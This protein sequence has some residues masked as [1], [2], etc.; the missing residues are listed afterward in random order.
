MGKGEERPVWSTYDPVMRRA[1][2]IVAEGF[3]FVLFGFGV[4]NDQSPHDFA[5]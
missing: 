2:V 1:S 5:E 4:M 3:S